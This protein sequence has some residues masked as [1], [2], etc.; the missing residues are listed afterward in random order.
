VPM[1]APFAR[2]V[3]VRMAAPYARTVLVYART[4]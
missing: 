2:T 1:A 4:D 3:L